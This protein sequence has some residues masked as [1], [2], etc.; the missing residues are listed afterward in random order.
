M[1]EHLEECL[2]SV[3]LNQNLQ[4]QNTFQVEYYCLI[5]FYLAFV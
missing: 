5:L 3:H 2:L 4:R 1:T